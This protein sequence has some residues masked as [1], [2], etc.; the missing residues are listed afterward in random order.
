LTAKALG[1]IVPLI[2][3]RLPAIIAS[4][5][6][7]IERRHHEQPGSDQ[8]GEG[9]TADDRENAMPTIGRLGPGN[10]I[11]RR[12]D[13]QKLSIP[14]NLHSNLQLLSNLATKG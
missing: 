4:Q 2:R 7:A 6:S 5:R 14:V 3:F 13:I 12:C 1:L 9:D 8:Q 11:L 10:G